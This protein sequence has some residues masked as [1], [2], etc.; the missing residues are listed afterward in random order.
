M[1]ENRAVV[2]P[3]VKHPFLVGFLVA[4]LLRMEIDMSGSE[5]HGLI[6]RQCRRKPMHCLC[7]LIRIRRWKLRVLITRE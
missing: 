5:G 6:R 4:E 2:F 3:M 7:F 1:S